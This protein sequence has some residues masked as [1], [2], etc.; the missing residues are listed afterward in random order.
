M[1]STNE[2]IIMYA[3]NIK[4]NL[5]NCGLK[6][7]RTSIETCNVPSKEELENA[8]IVTPL[9]WDAI[10]SFKRYQNQ[11]DDSYEE[12]KLA[13]K[14]C[15]NAIDS[16]RNALHQSFIKHVGI[17]GFPGGGKTWCM[18]Y[19]LIYSISCGLKVTTSTM[20]CNRALQLGGVHAHKLFN[21]P[22]ERLTPHRRAELSIIKLM[23]CPKRLEFLRS[24]D[25]IFF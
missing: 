9:N 16:H 11:I 22:T 21:L 25:V 20:M 23:K 17:L 15:I 2:D 8:T 3:Q 10:T 7:M 1:A 5:I 14:I 24:I 18:M 12:Q 13:I 6:E 19:C 4:T